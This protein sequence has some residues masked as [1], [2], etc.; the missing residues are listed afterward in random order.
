MGIWTKRRAVIGFALAA[1]VSAFAAGCVTPPPP[2][3]VNLAL[4]AAP[5]ANPDSAGRPSP[6]VVRIYQLAAPAEFQQADFFA[7]YDQAAQTLGP[8]LVGTDEV[9]LAPGQAQTVTVTLKPGAEVLGLIASYRDIDQAQWR[10]L[11]TPP[12]NQT[13]QSAVTVS[14]TAMMLAGS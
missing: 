14:R 1:S 5:D 13:S 8:N 6:V 7:L 9:A 3:V 11:I 12:K 10:V 2:T 4:A